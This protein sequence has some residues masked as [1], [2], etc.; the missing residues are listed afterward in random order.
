M[1]EHTSGPKKSW[2]EGVFN[3]LPWFD[4]KTVKN[5]RVM[6]VGVGALGNEVLKNLA[7]FGVGQLVMVDFDTVEY[8]NLSRSILFR[9]H[10]SQTNRPK[11]TVAAERLREINPEIKTH[12][13]VGNIGTDVGLGLFRDA[14]VIIG[15]LDSRLARYQVNQLCFRA[16]KP[17]IDAGIENLEGYVRIFSP[18][19]NCYECSLTAEEKHN[20]RLKTGCPDVARAHVL[21]GRVA[22]T[23]VSASVMGAIQVQEALKIIHG[24]RG[25]EKRFNTLH[26]KLF[27]FDGLHMTTHLFRMKNYDE[28]CVS[29]DGWDPVLEVPGLGADV[30]VSEALKLIR[31]GTGYDD[32]CINLKNNVFVRSLIWEHSEKEM[33]VLLPSSRVPGFLQRQKLTTDPD[34]AIMQDYTDIVNQD[35]PWQHM[36]LHEIGVPYYDVLQVSV[37]GG[38][39]YVSLT[40]DGNSFFP[41]K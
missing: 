2:G 37:P 16:N 9:E 29:H 10:D 20:L 3:L 36:T 14:D 27:K 32:V 11:V 22:T 4:L 33:E 31:E 28:T 6:V 17:W 24:G 35:F 26:G 5:A 13:I 7:L 38:Y 15:C 39:V 41:D 1:V 19:E 34:E 18:E 21:A 12:A 8:T 30:S 40:E 23:P 25:D